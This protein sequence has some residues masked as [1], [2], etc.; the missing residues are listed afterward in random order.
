[1]VEAEPVTFTQFAI[2]APE[3]FVTKP[4]VVFIFAKKNEFGI[5]FLARPKIVE[6]N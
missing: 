3:I 5:V 6:S 4:V 1:M 2:E